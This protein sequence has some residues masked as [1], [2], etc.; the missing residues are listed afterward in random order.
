MTAK[1]IAAIPVPMKHYVAL[2]L[3]GNSKTLASSNATIVGNRCVQALLD[4]NPL[5]ADQ[6]RDILRIL[7]EEG[8]YETYEYELSKRDG[9]TYIPGKSEV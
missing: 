5:T 4:K 7:C 2:K 6:W 1:E 3:L 8:L 9:P